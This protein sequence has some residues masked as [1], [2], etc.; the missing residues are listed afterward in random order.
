MV[1]PDFVDDLADAGL[2]AEAVEE[3]EPLGEEGPEEGA[4]VERE[5][6]CA[7]ELGAFALDG[8]RGV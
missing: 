5:S 7:R 1:E 8:C 3:V 6:G 2:D 4:A